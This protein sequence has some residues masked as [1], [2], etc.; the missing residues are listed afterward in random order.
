[1]FEA[2]FRERITISF[3]KEALKS[4]LSIAAES[5]VSI[6]RVIRHAVDKF[7]EKWKEG[8][9]EQLFLPLQQEERRLVGGIIEQKNS[10]KIPSHQR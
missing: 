5:D 10:E 3:D 1:M 2:E 9:Q 6:A 7:L 4:V 8:G